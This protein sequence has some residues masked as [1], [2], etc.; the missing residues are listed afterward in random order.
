MI[1]NETCVDALM[2]EAK[3][4]VENLK[5]QEEF[6]VKELFRGFEWKRLPQ[7]TRIRLGSEFLRYAKSVDGECR[8]EVLEGEKGKTSQNQQIYR[9]R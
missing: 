5:T 7:G 1:T 2:D 3:E 9:K 8:I 6:I 4:I